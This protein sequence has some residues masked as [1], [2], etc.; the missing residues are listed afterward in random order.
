ML[1]A[2]ASKTTLQ[3]FAVQLTEDQRKYTIVF[4]SFLQHL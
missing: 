4:C 3:Y 1:L 2:A